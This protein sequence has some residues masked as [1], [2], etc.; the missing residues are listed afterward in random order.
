MNGRGGSPTQRTCPCGHVFHVGLQGRVGEEAQ[1]EKCVQLDAFFQLDVFFVLQGSRGQG[2]HGGEGI[3]L[4]TKMRP[5]MDTF[6]FLAGGRGLVGPPNTK[7]QPNMK[8]APVVFFVFGWFVSGG[9]GEM[10]R[11]RK[12]PTHENVPICGDVF[13]LGMGWESRTR[14]THPSGCVFCV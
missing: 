1:H 14:T 10:G 8:N 2:K 5:H 13:M 3:Q 9:R 11:Q 6:L 7:N 12:G 4:D